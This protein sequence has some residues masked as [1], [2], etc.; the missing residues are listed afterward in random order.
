M[1]WRVGAMHVRIWIVLGAL[2]CGSTKSSP[3]GAE[4][5]DPFAPMS[6]TS[7]G[8][9]NLSPDLDAILEHGALEGACDR[10][11]AGATDRKTM[12]LCGKS[13]FFDQ[14][15]GTIGIPE[16]I[17]SYFAG[18]FPDVLGP[19]FSKLG[20]IEDPRSPDHRPLGLGYTTPSGSGKNLAFTCASCHFNKLPDGRYSIGAPNHNWQYGTEIL[21]FTIVPGLAL[22]QSNAADHDPDAVAR[23]QPIVDAITGDFALRTRLVTTLFSLQGT[24]SAPALS[25]AD[26]HAYATWLP[27]TLDFI[28]KPMPYDDEVMTIG[29]MIGIWSQPD[30]AEVHASGMTNA[31]LSW[32]GN[33]H[34]LLGFVKAFV[35]IGA[36]DVA[37][38]PP[39]K[40]EP[41]VEYVYTLRAPENPNPPP[42]NEVAAGKVLFKE[43]G[44][45]DCHDGPRGSGKRLYDYEEIGTDS[46]MKYWLDS[47]L[48]GTPCC[49]FQLDDDVALHKNIKSPRLVGMWTL[50]RFL[51]NGSVDSLGDLLCL[52]G[53]RGTITTP[54][55]GDGGHL[56]G[57]DL[58]PSEKSALIAYLLAH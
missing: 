35:V 41:L 48:S 30:E 28:I 15:F 29:K 13:M 46:Q 56:Y 17:V 18:N 3:D 42:A 47:T 6:D 40:L 44:C 11:F 23:V 24:T 55:Y 53:P 50:K 49:G 5:G 36:G 34:S 27:G 2:G 54:A 20:C 10:Y 21:T 8:L 45:L 43:Q 52:N 12:L 25:L 39:E 9:T 37:G 14:P 19:G 57:C 58:A 51:H 31:M 38:F 32:T 4:E 26:E 16:P 1:C 7:E 33:G 22:G